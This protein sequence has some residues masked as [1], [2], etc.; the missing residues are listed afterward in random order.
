[1]NSDAEVATSQLLR[2][3][4][5]TLCLC[6]TESVAIADISV[7]ELSEVWLRPGSRCKVQYGK[8]A[9]RRSLD[10]RLRGAFAALRHYRGNVRSAKATHTPM[11]ML[12]GSN[13]HGL[14]KGKGIR[15]VEPDFL[16]GG[17]E[18]RLF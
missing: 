18:M 2:L 11:D 5:L 7:Y 1:M 13:E 3:Q 14:R 15:Y 8:G 17:P 12:H 16:S 9:G 10:L 4:N 6:W